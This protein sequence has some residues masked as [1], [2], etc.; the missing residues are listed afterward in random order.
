MEGEPATEQKQ[1]V[2]L[3]KTMLTIR[4]SKASYP[5]LRQQLLQMN[6]KLRCCFSAGGAPHPHCFLLMPGQLTLSKWKPIV[7]YN[8]YYL[9]HLPEH[10]FRQ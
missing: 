1:E 7:S 10:L 4:G 3:R 9:C 6:D 2:R 5:Q 8:N